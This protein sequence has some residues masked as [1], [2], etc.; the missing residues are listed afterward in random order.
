MPR[1]S[2]CLKDLKS[3]RI[4]LLQGGLNTGDFRFRQGRLFPFWNSIRSGC[5][6]LQWRLPQSYR[7]SQWKNATGRILYKT[8]W[9]GL[10][11]LRVAPSRIGYPVSSFASN[12][13]P[14]SAGRGW[15]RRTTL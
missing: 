7:E 14:Y 4:I 1:K 9:C 6:S 11:N 12:R 10:N 3:F 15:A 2:V 8:E 5:R 13:R